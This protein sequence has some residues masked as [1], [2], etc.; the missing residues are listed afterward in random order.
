MFT[1][2]KFVEEFWGA[3]ACCIVT[4]V[5]SCSASSLNTSPNYVQQW[6]LFVSSFHEVMIGN[7]ITPTSSHSS[8]LSVWHTA[9]SRSRRTIDPAALFIV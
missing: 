9:S 2:R 1:T 5:T 3:T 6:T 7:V 8:L 4:L